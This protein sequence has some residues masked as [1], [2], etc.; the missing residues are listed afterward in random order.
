MLLE[1]SEYGK[2]LLGMTKS[3][4]ALRIRGQTLKARSR[5]TCRTI[6]CWLCTRR[7]KRNGSTASIQLPRSILILSLATNGSMLLTDTTARV[8]TLGTHQGAN[9]T[10]RRCYDAFRER[11]KTG[12]GTCG[13]V[14]LAL[15]LVKKGKIPLESCWREPSSDG[16]EQLHLL[17][18]G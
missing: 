12:G 11:R 17:P 18:M 1:I 7:C 2:L 15:R 14:T 3:R 5:Y 9:A 13:C 10:W 6:R 8:S 4:V 16:V